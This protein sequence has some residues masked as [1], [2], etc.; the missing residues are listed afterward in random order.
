MH[1]SVLAFL[2]K[3]DPVNVAG[4][5]VVEFGAFNVNG[6]AREVI[7]PMKPA[8]YEGYD[9]IEGPGVD[10][11]ADFGQYCRSIQELE[12]PHVVFCLNTLEHSKDWRCVV[13]NI[14]YLCK[15]GG[16]IVISVP[17]RGFPYHNPPDFWRFSLEQIRQIFSDTKI[18]LLEEDP[19]IQGV[20]LRA[21]ALAK[22]GT[23]ALEEIEPDKVPMGNAAD[24]EKIW[25]EL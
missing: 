2:G 21:R 4:K 11:V 15:A 7:M 5:Y 22:T 10:K 24:L 14:K 20:L 18:E 8:I 23:V 6:S 1:E 25:E 16:L 9:R 17:S 3:I 12:K 13:R 19:Q